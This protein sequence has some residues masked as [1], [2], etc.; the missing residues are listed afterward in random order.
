MENKDSVA[1]LFGQDPL[2]AI[3]WLASVAIAIVDNGH[4]DHTRT[5]HNGAG[6]KIQAAP[7]T[8][9]I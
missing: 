4:S 8:L 7:T 3:F 2:F 5:G 1:C 9:F 6:D